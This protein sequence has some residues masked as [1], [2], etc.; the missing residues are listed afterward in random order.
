M[1]RKE[2]EMESLRRWMPVLVLA[3]GL[4]VSWGSFQ[5]QLNVLADEVVELKVEDKDHND[6]QVVDQAELAALKANQKAIKEDVQEIKEAQ[7]EQN[8]KLDK[9]LEEL[10]NQ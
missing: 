1:E 2:S 7:K 6:Q 4:A 9:I 3:C 8:Q 5:T 10:R